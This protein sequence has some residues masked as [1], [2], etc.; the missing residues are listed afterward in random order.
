VTMAAFETV[1]DWFNQMEVKEDKRQIDV[2]M[3]IQ[4]GRAYSG[5]A[6]MVPVK[7]RNLMKKVMVTDNAKVYKENKAMM[8]EGSIA[9]M[10]DSSQ[11]KEYTLVPSK[12]SLL[13]RMQVLPTLLTFWYLKNDN[14][15]EVNWKQNQVAVVTVKCKEDFWYI[16]DYLKGA[17]MLEVGCDYSVFRQG[18]SPD[19]EHEDN[20]E[21]GRWIL[22]VD[23]ESLDNLWQRLIAVMVE[24]DMMLVTGVVVS[25]RKYGDKMAVWM[26]DAKEEEVMMV[27][28]IVKD[29]LKVKAGMLVFRMHKKNKGALGRAITL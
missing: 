26:R 29:K 25:R 13:R 23:K 12:E 18:I 7:D 24:E 16:H 2:A 28:R 8:M 17:S 22:S 21:G 11:K 3:I 10:G 15:S 6:M 1:T 4:K 19:W 14:T 9:S 20:R 5:Q 27:G